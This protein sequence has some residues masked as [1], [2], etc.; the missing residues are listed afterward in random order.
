[1][2]FPLPSLPVLVLQ[3][4]SSCPLRIQAFVSLG[5]APPFATSESLQTT[6]YQFAVPKRFVDNADGVLYV[7]SDCINCAACSHFAADVFRRAA[8]DDHHVAFDQPSAGDV[9]RLDRVRAALSACP[10]A[11]IRVERAAKDAAEELSSEDEALKR[12]LSLRRKASGL[13][14]PF[15][16]PL[17]PDVDTGVFFLGS[18][19]RA[20]FGATPYLASGRAPD[21]SAVSVM[22]DTPKFSSQSVRVVRSLLAEG[23]LGPDY[24]FLTHVDDTADHLKWRKEFTSLK[25]IF[26]AGDLGRHNW[27]GDTTLEDVEVLLRSADEE[28]EDSFR[29]WDLNGNPFQ[30]SLNAGVSWPDEAKGD[31]LVLHTPGHSPGSIALLTRRGVLFTGDTYAWTT[32]DGGH[33]SGF[34]RYG[35]NMRIQS[36]TI[37]KFGKI[38]GLF[39][40]VA[41]GHGHVRQYASLATNE[42]KEQAKKQDINAVLEELVRHP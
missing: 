18:H 20:S 16:R 31:F 19:N 27:I 22:V 24:L 7:N 13:D 26:H 23:S 28:D 5:A 29:A 38:A 36:N 34:P 8:S 37:R 33:M 15:P 40:V 25:R 41:P 32:R 11:A 12:K 6:T 10:V 2:R 1:M 3:L 30:V 9:D 21:G 17:L 42:E 4:I 35:N 14:P 39:D